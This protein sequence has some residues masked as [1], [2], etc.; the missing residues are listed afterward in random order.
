MMIRGF[1]FSCAVVSSEPQDRINS[2]ARLTP[3]MRRTLDLISC[4]LPYLSA[5]IAFGLWHTL[6][7]PVNLGSCLACLALSGLSGFTDMEEPSGEGI[8]GSNNEQL[9]RGF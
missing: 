3:P 8:H 9:V 7:E 2:S 6:L 4:F 1:F 5:I